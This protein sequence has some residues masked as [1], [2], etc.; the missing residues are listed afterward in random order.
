MKVERVTPK[1][2]EREKA[3]EY[4]LAVCK[5]GLGKAGMKT[6]NLGGG[7]FGTAV[8]VTFG[9]GSEAVVKFLR[10]DEML[11]KETHD[12]KLL[13]ENC[14]V[15]MPKV[16]YSRRAGSGI[17]LDCYIMDKIEGSTL[18]MS[19]GKLLYSKNARLK[20]ADEVASALHGIH[21]CR[22][23]SFGDTLNP[24]FSSWIDCY[25]PFMEDVYSAAKQLSD[26]G[27][28]PAEIVLAMTR[29]RD[30]FS[31][32]FSEP[33]REA[34]LIHGDLNVG[35]IMVGRGLEITGFIDP[36]N[37]MYADR[38]YDLFQFNNLTGKRFF[39]C[40]TYLKKYGASEKVEQKLAFYGLWNEVY[41]FIK[42][43]TLIPF[44][45]NPLVK[46]MN[47]VLDRGV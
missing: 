12:L 13:A 46:N 14:A 35:N 15:R 31:D 34:G 7:S 10:A 26:E 22:L 1:S 17:P 29:A 16:L 25:E 4:A 24:R 19:F 32:I 28:L 9:D 23:D 39:L 43:G 3:A 45:M 2:L 40:D 30:K 42:A 33:V 21:E 8:G 27:Q 18:F 36:L 47:A 20:F 41:C 38:E 6:K 5:E 37:S 44:I 11:E